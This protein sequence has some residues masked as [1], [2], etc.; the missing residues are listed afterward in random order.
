MTF[1]LA[2]L[3]LL[4]ALPAGA[5][6][7]GPPQGEWREQVHAIPVPGG[8]T[9]QARSCRPPGDGPVPLALVTH[10]DP[11]VTS[12]GARRSSATS[13]VEIFCWS[14]EARFFLDRGMAVLAV[15]RRGFWPS[16]GRRYGPGDGCPADGMAA[17]AR[18]EAADLAVAL[19]YG[20]ALPGVAAQGTVLS[21]VGTGAWAVLGLPGTPG[22][23]GIAAAIVAAPTAPRAA[24]PPGLDCDDRPLVAAARR[25]AA[26]VSVP[27]LWLQVEGERRGAGQGPDAAAAWAASAAAPLRFE[28]LPAPDP[29]GVP[30]PYQL[31]NRVDDRPVPAGA[32]AARFLDALR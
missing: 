28:A 9:L 18:A 30:T 25:L 4:L 23:S 11:V 8:P 22:Q 24:A 21:G 14:N 10:D 7:L 17:L 29:R 12:F 19:A 32:A 6:P 20:R 13:S 16:T 2:A 31:I 1:R 26:Y 3:A 27:V 15:M 5:A